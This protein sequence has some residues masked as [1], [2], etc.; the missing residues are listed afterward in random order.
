M[1]VVQIIIIVQLNE[2]TKSLKVGNM[3]VHISAT[4]IVKTII[5]ILVLI[6]TDRKINRFI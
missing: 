2:I 5:I 4:S 3:F 6:Q 1:H